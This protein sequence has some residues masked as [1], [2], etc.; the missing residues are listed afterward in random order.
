[1]ALETVGVREQVNLW[2][3]QADQGGGLEPQR[4]D[5]YLV[6]FEVAV[7]GVQAA[8]NIQPKIGLV[9]PQ[10]IRSISFPETRVKADPIRRDSMPCN[11]PSWDDPLDVIKLSFL[12]DTSNLENSSV[13]TRFLDTW[14]ALTRAGRGTRSGFTSAPGWLTLNSKWSVDFRFPIHL[15]LLRGTD[16]PARNTLSTAGFARFMAQSTSAFRNQMAAASVPQI[17]IPGISDALRETLTLSTRVSEETY[18]AQFVLGSASLTSHLIYTLKNAWLAG[19]KLSDF[20]YTESTLVTVDANFY[21]D[22][23]ETEALDIAGP[24]LVDSNSVARSGF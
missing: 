24:S 14:L 2:G 4:N 18:A 21:A 8:S 9:I 15:K 20:T 5:L 16:K 7:E 13:V 10:F 11:M 6:D 19:Y 1:M 12:L 3:K 17:G 22:S 23:V